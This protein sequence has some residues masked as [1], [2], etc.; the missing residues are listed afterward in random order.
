MNNWSVIEYFSTKNVRLKVG[1]VGFIL[2][3]VIKILWVSI[4]SRC[5]GIDGGG[6]SIYY[7]WLCNQTHHL[8][9]RAR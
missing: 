5:S 3:S 8:G 1:Q 2:F 4:L 6:F 7:E 9:A